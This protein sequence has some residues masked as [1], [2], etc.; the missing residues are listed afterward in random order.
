MLIRIE[1]LEVYTIIGVNNWEREVKQKVIIDVEIE[2]EKEPASDSIKNAI[3]YKKLNKKIYNS[4]TKTK[5]KLLE[6]L[7][8][9]VLKIC[10]VKNSKSAFV[11]V[12]KPG[13]LRY[14]ESVSIIKTWKK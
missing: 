13:A 6:T 3:D 12:T 5:F 14:A 10:M 2:Y 11:K 9:Y 7:A 4:V 8:D 1:G